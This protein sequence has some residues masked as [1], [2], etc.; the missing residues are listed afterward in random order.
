MKLSSILFILLFIPAL[1]FGQNHL[2]GTIVDENDLPLPATIYIPQLEK[3]TSADLDGEFQLNNIPNGNHEIIFSFLG[4]AA[5]SQ[6]IRFPRETDKAIHIVLKTSVVEMDPVILSVPF[7]QLQG[8]NVMKVEQIRISDLQ[9]TG[10]LN[11]AD[12]ISNMAGVNTIN[13]GAGIGK[14]VIRGLSSN[15]V[16]TYAQGIRLENQQFGEEH[17]LGVSES[18]IESVEV[19][20]GPASLLYGSDALGG[21]LY[22]NPERFAAEDSFAADANASLYSNTKG[23]NVNLG[24]K[25]TVE[26]FGILARGAYSEHS[27]YKTGNG[28]R[29]T[30]SRFLEKDFKAGA[31]Y[32]TDYFT[33]A[34]RYN[35]NETELGIAEG[36]DKQTTSMSMEFPYQEVTNHILSW[37]NTL[38]FEKSKLTAKIGYITNDRKEFEEEHD[39]DD[40]EHDHDH[41]EEGMEPSLR[42][43]LSTLSYDVKYHLPSNEKLET[44]IGV[45]GMN[46]KNKNDGEEVLIPDATTNDI[47]VFATGHYHLEK[48][49]FQAGLRL[50][51]RKI[52]IKETWDEH[53]QS[54]IDAASKDFTSLNAALGVKWNLLDYLVARLNVASGFRAP[55]LAELTS[56]GVHHGTFRY[57]IG[58]LDLTH[59]QNLQVDL[60]MELKLRNVE[61]YANGFFNTV[62]DYIYLEPTNEAIEDVSVY[63]YQQNN[64]KL[65]GGEFGFHY[66]P[67]GADWLHLDNTYEMVIGKQN[68]GTY[69][70]FI[71]A[72]TLSNRVQV[73]FK[74]G[75]IFENTT[76][77]VQLKTSF[78]QDKLSTFETHTGGYSLVNL[79]ASTSFDWSNS[80]IEFGVSVT[81]LFDKEYVS[82]LSRLKQNLIPDIGRN[83]I[84]N[85]KIQL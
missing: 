40:A 61:L 78:S 79:G 51:S 73:F 11:L 85:I 28:K 64:A 38:S 34:L 8:D 48:V 24:V 57:E 55:N 18:G 47:G 16:L 77:F 68:N 71:P 65:Y 15:R 83:I 32:K 56:D 20:K 21:V 27:D 46:Q 19:I 52:N 80:R 43:K 63:R 35:Y 75:N 12:G 72:H 37:D 53:N 58:S 22:L 70:P 7:H 74:D 42:L 1:M 41:D 60:S 23:S 13:T 9:K 59:E 36:I 26:G 31:Q 29:A 3:G 44:I 33:S 5:H 67:T 84:G 6:R 45:Q 4:Y 39:H 62:K 14:P 69:L 10:A 49:D 76:A 82:H 25:N 30:N 2:S 81:N 66:H 17:G 54:Y 50:D